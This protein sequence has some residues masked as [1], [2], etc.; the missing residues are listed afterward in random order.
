[1]KKITERKVYFYPEVTKYSYIENN[2]T[3]PDEIQISPKASEEKGTQIRR[4]S[5]VIKKPLRLNL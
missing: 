5:R 1:M 2:D 4:S 3:E